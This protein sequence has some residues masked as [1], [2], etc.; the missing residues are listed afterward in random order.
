MGR[1]KGKGGSSL[2]QV[3]EELEDPGVMLVPRQRG[4]TPGFFILIGFVPP[5]SRQTAVVAFLGVRGKMVVA[6]V[7][8]PSGLN[9]H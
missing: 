7:E 6:V 9:W 8:F 3:D 5:L 4:V 2:E 1:E